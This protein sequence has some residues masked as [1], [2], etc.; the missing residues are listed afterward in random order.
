MN[1]APKA[2]T[3]CQHLEKYHIQV[4]STGQVAGPCFE[5]DCKCRLY[6]APRTVVTK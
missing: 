1:D 3:S 5:L 2:C 4:R 6:M